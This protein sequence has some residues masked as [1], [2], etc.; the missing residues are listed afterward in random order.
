MR[1]SIHTY[2]YFV[3][4]SRYKSMTE[5]WIW[6]VIDF[7]SLHLRANYM[8]L[9]SGEDRQLITCVYSVYIIT[10]TQPT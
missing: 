8:Y 1:F 2:L 5:D 4:T 7:M 10:Y 6:L 9:L 3:I